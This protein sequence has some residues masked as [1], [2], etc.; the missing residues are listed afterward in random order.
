MI[1]QGGRP[2]K[3]RKC[4]VGGWKSRILRRCGTSRLVR[5]CRSPPNG[6]RARECR[7]K[8]FAPE[9]FPFNSN[10]IPTKPQSMGSSIITQNFLGKLPRKKFSTIEICGK[11][12]ALERRVSACFGGAR[13]AWSLATHAGANQNLSVPLSI[14]ELTVKFEAGESPIEGRKVLGQNV[15]F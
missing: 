14:D 15:D 6:V 5:H 2:S 4:R 10:A 3:K 11:K 7:V 1:S 9:P 8:H 13:V 12:V